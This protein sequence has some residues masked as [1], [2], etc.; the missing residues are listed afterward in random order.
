[1]YSFKLSS[2][3]IHIQ[4]CRARSMALTE[5]WAAEGVLFEGV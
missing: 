5:Y 2:H 3:D 4:K 1:M